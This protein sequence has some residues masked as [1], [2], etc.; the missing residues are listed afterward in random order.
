[1]T[2]P[3]ATIAQFERCRRVA[4]GREDPSSDELAEF[5]RLIAREYARAEARRAAPSPQLEL[6]EAA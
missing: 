3:A 5:P 4:D 6:P 1:M 2:S